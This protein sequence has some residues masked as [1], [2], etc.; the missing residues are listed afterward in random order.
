MKQHINIYKGGPLRVSP[1]S[2]RDRNPC[3]SLVAILIAYLSFSASL[4]VSAQVVTLDSVLSTI[5]RQNPM[6]QEYDNKVKALNIYTEGAKSWMAPMVGAGTFM[7]PYSSPMS[8]HGETVDRGMVMFSFEQ[9]IPNPSRLNAN[10]RYLESKASVEEQAR[11][12]RFN[13]LR[14]EAKAIYYQWLVAEQKIKTLREN[15]RIVELMVKLA[16]LR[17]PY[18]QG[19]LGNIYKAEGRL[20]E[21]QNMLLM[22]Q[23]DIEEKR[24]RL[25]TLMNLPSTAAMFIDTTT[26]IRYEASP[27]MFDTAALSTQRSDVKQL[28]NTIR[29]MKLSQQLQQ[30]QAKPD[31]K[32]RFDHMQPIQSGMPA[33]FTAMAMVSIPIA[34][35]S[36]RMYKSEVKGMHYD[37]EAMK[38]GRE[39][40]LIE[41]RG[42]LA[43]MASR[44][45]R[46]QQQ[47][48]NYKTKIIPAL[49]KNYQTT[50]LAYEE[51]RE[52][53]PMV[54]DGWEALNM[55]QMEY[56]N[57]L[58]EYYTMIVAY[59]KE[60]EK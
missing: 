1:D 55:A 56:L 25:T 51:N 22:T 13:T 3:R 50:M 2:Y 12:Y 26:Q 27:V 36:S 48:E 24:Y 54:I 18:N 59:E 33:Q 60:I 19:S 41:A 37:I 52:Q 31:F 21:V 44:L 14:A 28:D 32:I 10:K 57:K 17:Y 23:G 46:M 8:A 40:V 7:T 34:P 39:A 42:M 29:S 20:S 35:W 5:N 47:L 9:D 43:G 11:S 49:Q 16:K 53:L 6:L 38:K 4:N 45:T 58:E 15:E 30:Y